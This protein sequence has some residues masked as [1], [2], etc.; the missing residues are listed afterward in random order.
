MKYSTGLLGFGVA[1]VGGLAF[2]GCGNSDSAPQPT[3][4]AA[5]EPAA[6]QQALRAAQ[7]AAAPLAP[8]A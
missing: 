1:V 3:S 7:Q 6:A 8:V 2:A 4:A 5:A